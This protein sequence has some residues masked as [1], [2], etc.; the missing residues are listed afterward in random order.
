M[1]DPR[2]QA[3][4]RDQCTVFL[5]GHGPVRAADLLASIPADTVPDRYGDGGVAAE[6]EA[7][8]AGCSASRPPST[9]PVARWPS[10]RCCACTPT[11]GSAG[12][13]CT[14]RCAIWTGTRTGPSSACTA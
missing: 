6:L 4:L 14:A 9:C 8:V 3:T 13:S 1:T 12:R 10:N 5:T 7:E 2:E 11:G